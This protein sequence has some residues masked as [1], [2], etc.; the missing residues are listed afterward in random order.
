MNDIGRCLKCKRILE[1]AHLKHISNGTNKFKIL[2]LSPSR[3]SNVF[4]TNK[5][6]HTRGAFNVYS[7]ASS[8]GNIATMM[9]AKFYFVA[10]R[11]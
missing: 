10:S 5:S 7:L 3:T 11:P 2:P 6:E 4:S 9:A 1:L 8:C